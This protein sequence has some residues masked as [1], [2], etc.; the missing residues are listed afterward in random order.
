MGWQSKV[1]DGARA[2]RQDA[3]RSKTRGKATKPGGLMDRAA[4]GGAV[5]SGRSTGA[6]ARVSKATQQFRDMQAQG[7][8]W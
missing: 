4:Q 2:S 3:A 6:E 8:A 5:R 7:T 1:A